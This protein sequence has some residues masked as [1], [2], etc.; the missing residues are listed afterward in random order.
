MRTLE[1]RPVRRDDQ[2]RRRSRDQRV[3]E[4]RQKVTILFFFIRRNCSIWST[5][6]E[7]RRYDESRRRFYYNT[8]AKSLT[9]RRV[10]KTLASPPRDNDIA[11]LSYY[12]SRYY[13]NDTKR[14]SSV[15]LPSAVGFH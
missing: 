9:R 3:S 5:S 4:A 2:L 1:G 13:D 10:P 7:S 15:Q 6:A 12:A 11:L 8:G 14:S